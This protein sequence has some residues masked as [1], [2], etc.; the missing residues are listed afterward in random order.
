MLRLTELHIEE[1]NIDALLAYARQFI[2]TVEL[3]WY[4]S[5]AEI[6]VRLQRSIFPEGVMYKDSV[7]TNSKIS[8]GF[9]IIN[10]FASSQTTNVTPLGWIRQAHHMIPSETFNKLRIYLVS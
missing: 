10:D 1:T 8:R 5:K 7:F 9:E 6:K 2:K 4:D 3:A